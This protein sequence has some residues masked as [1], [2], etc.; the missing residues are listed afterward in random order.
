MIDRLTRYWVYGGAIAGVLLLLLLPTVD[1]GWSLALVLVYL[2][3]P[4]YMLHQLEEHYADRFQQV[5]N[6]TIGH[7]QDVL[8]HRAIFVINIGVWILNLLSFT[9]AVHWGSGWG[10][11]GVYAMVINA[12]VHIAQALRMRR[13]NP[14]LLTA[15]VLFLPVGLGGLWTIWATG[16]ANLLQHLV[17]TV[18]GLAIHGAIIVYV[19]GNARRLGVTK[20]S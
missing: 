20:A 11:I 6:E 18:L 3:M 1:V 12:V 19:L 10:L 17:A 13:Y 5:I 9:L 2:Q 15:I 14:G 7:G 8:P 16:E 4:T